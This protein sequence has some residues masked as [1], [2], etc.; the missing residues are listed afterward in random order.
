ME[1]IRQKDIKVIE[2]NINNILYDTNKYIKNNYDTKIDYYKKVI[3]II[4]E[5][6]INNK[7]IIYGGYAIDMLIKYK[8]NNDYIYDEYDYRDIEIYSYEPLVDLKNICDILYKKGYQNILG[9]QAMHQYTYTIIVD[10][11]NYCDISY[12]PKEIY[13]KI[14]TN[15][16]NN[17]IYISPIIIYLDKLLSITDLVASDWRLEKD[18]GRIYK[19]QKYYKLEFKKEKIDK[20]KKK[21]VNEIIDKI[22]NMK[23]I[24]IV[25]DYSNNYYKKLK[26]INKVNKLEIITDNYNKVIN[27][28]KNI[29]KNI[30]NKKVEEKKYYPFFTFL[31]KRTELLI[32]DKVY[33]VIYSNNNK[34]IPFRILDNNIKISTFNFNIMYNMI[35]YIYNYIY[36]NNFYIKYYNN[37]IRSLIKYRN[38]YLKK[39]NLNIL[40]N[41]PYQDIIL[42]CVGKSVNQSRL[43]RLNIANRIKKGLKTIFEYRPEQKKNILNA[44]FSFLNMTG[45]EKL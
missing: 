5:Y 19:M 33:I 11:Q 37:S 25:G 26:V 21:K 13:N 18:I 34:C 14:P 9:K 39:N 38:K 32:D 12:M 20:I 1:I 2:N 44:D 17:V 43:F 22:K 40:D 4:L 16:I 6:I 7:K 28:C 35:L 23:D 45:L 31:D 42:N 10:F 27:D 41:S 36:N 24:V 29:L 3:N 15:V 8:N 30:Y